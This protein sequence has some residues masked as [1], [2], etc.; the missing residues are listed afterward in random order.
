MLK[1]FCVLSFGFI[2]KYD[3]FEQFQHFTNKTSIYIAGT[4]T[5]KCLKEKL[6]TDKIPINTAGI[7]REKSK[8]NVYMPI[9]TYIICFEKS[10]KNLT[11]KKH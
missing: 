2:R 4:T 1:V 5:K 9:E 8:K 3:D 10:W 7:H 6:K 11:S